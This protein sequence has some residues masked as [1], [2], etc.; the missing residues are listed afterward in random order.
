[1]LFKSSWR[2]ECGRIVS[3]KDKTCDSCGRER[4]NVTTSTKSS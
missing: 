3:G 2:C 1:M 4:K